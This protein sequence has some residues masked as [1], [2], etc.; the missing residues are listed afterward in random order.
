M[1][2]T[3][4]QFGEQA[5][6][7][8]L[9]LTAILTL[10]A[11]AGQLG[12]LRAAGQA[13]LFLLTL[14]IGAWVDGWRTRVVMVLADAARAAVLGGLAVAI[15]LGLLRLPVLLVAVFAVGSMSVLFDV[16]WQMAATAREPL[17]LPVSA[18]QRPLPT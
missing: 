3:A 2:Q 16:A 7:I 12:L 15:L 17:T 11:S 1:G 5:T 9:P 18:R 13:P 6:L 14:F 4:S 8:I 10:H